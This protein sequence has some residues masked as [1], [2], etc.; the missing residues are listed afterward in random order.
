[1]DGQSGGSDDTT[2]RPPGP[3][4]LWNSC[5]FFDADM[6]LRAKRVH[7]RRMRTSNRRGHAKASARRTDSFNRAIRSR[8]RR[9]ISNDV[10]QS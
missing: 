4:Q 5:N 1:M 3:D 7:P 9:Q 8:A 2:D 6:R 10:T